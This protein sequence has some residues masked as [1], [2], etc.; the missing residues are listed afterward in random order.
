MNESLIIYCFILR[1]NIHHDFQKVS[2]VIRNA[3][4]SALKQPKL[5]KSDTEQKPDRFFRSKKCIAQIR[6]VFVAHIR[7]LESR[8]HLEDDTLYLYLEFIRL[9]RPLLIS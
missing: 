8:H 3:T 6:A 9:K 2:C 4:H 1:L 7:F 5:S